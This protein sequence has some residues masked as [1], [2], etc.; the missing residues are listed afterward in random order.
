MTDDAAQPTEA[1]QLAEQVA[2]LLEEV[3]AANDRLATEVDRIIG[4]RAAVSPS[5]IE[6]ISQLAEDLRPAVSARAQLS[7]LDPALLLAGTSVWIAQRRARTHSA[8]ARAAH[9]W[10]DGAPA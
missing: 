6:R 8:A 7:D 1:G 5:T 10:S 4:S 3:Y 9:R 2:D